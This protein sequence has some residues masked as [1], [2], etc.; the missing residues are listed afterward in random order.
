MRWCS[1]WACCFP[2]PR[3]KFFLKKCTKD[4]EDQS[5]KARN[6]KVLWCNP[7]TVMAQAHVSAIVSIN[8]MDPTMDFTAIRKFG[9]KMILTLDWLRRY[10]GLKGW[11]NE[12]GS[13]GYDWQILEIFGSTSIKGGV[14]WIT[15]PDQQINGLKCTRKCGMV[16]GFNKIHCSMVTH[17]F[18]NSKKPSLV[19]GGQCLGGFREKQSINT[20]IK[21]IL[22]C[23]WCV[24]D[25]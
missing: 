15:G 1:I 2:H 7:C 17:F 16:L 6:Y 11:S 14:H 18:S 24:G 12:D 8:L 3:S 5:K 21:V 23:L 9:Q 19:A 4:L 13:K 25:S 22:F 20:W 10:V